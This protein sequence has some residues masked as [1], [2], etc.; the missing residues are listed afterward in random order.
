MAPSAGVATHIEAG[1]LVVNSQVVPLSR[2]IKV[3]EMSS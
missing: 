2:E 1:W 3:Y